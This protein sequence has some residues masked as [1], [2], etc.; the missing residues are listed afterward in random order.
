MAA[1]PGSLPGCG[2][3]AVAVCHN[4]IIR[5]VSADPNDFRNGRHVVYRLHAHVVLVTKYRRGAITDRVGELLIATTREV[6][7]RHDVTLVEAD[8][9]H[10]HLHLLLDYPPKIS[11]ST[12]VGA[13][14]TNSSRIVREQNWPEV[15]QALWGQHFWS[16]SYCV[17]STGGAPIQ[18]VRA[19]IASQREPNR[20]PGRPGRA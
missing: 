17:L 2:V 3:C 1:A 9:E 16:P 12:L 14:K 4:P 5:F 6:C 10:D 8:G 11:L 7:E 13:I 18:A 20:R 15:R 19:Y